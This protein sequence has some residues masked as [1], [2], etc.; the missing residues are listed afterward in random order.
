MAQPEPVATA[1]AGAVWS[2]QLARPWP[3]KARGEAE[4]AGPGGHKSGSPMPLTPGRRFM[5]L[6]TAQGM[7]WGERRG[8]PCSHRPW[9]PCSVR[10]GREEAPEPGSPSRPPSVLLEA[11]APTG[12][13]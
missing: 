13:P 3:H 11:P 10:A 2:Q 7:R 8:S 1:T 5:G 6:L 12:L 4:G 9:G